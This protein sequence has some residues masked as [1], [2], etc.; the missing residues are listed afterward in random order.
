MSCVLRIDGK[1]FKVD[2]FLKSSNLKPYRIYRKGEK[3]EIGKRKLE[4]GS[5]C[6]FDLSTANFNDFEQQRKDAVKFLKTHF[7][8]LNTVFSYGLSKSEIPTIDFGTATRMHN[9]EIQCDY[10]EPELLKLAG[11]LNFGIEIS[12]YH[13]SAEDLE[14]E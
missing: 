1:D 3:I 9:V 2:D 8:K 6:S 10:L 13:P 11:N 12:Q 7:D 5:G 4:E 14:S